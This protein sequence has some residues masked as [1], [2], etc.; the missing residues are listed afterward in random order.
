MPK[1]M[2]GASANIHIKQQNG[3]NARLVTGQFAVLQWKSLVNE[4][5]T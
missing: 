4:R 3:E 1:I 5:G 2:Q